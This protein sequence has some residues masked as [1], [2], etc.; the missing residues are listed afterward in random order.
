MI[1]L[2]DHLS[3]HDIFRYN[4]P[5]RNDV[6]T[7]ASDI[8]GCLSRLDRIYVSLNLTRSALCTTRAVNLTDHKLF[9]VKINISFCSRGRGYY[10][11]NTL[12]L[13]D[14][15]VENFVKERLQ[16]LSTPAVSFDAWENFKIDVIGYFRRLGKN[17]AKDRNLNRKSLEDRIRNVQVLLSN[18]QNPELRSYLKKLHE[19]LE[20]TNSFYIA[21]CRHN[22]Y[23][24]DF[25]NDK[26]SIATAKALQRKD[27]EQRH[28]FSVL[29]EDGSVATEPES[30]K[31]A[32]RAFY[33]DIFK[34]RRIDQELLNHFIES[35]QPTLSEEEQDT[36]NAEIFE[37]EVLFA[38]RSTQGKKTPGLDG[39]PI[40]FYWKFC[41]ELVPIL[42]KLYNGF[43][44]AGKMHDSA[45]QG[46]ISLLYKGKG[47]RNNLANW[48]P[49]TMLNLDYK[50]YAK[51]L[52]RRVQTVIASVVRAD[53]SCAVPGRTILDSI[54]SV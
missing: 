25:V 28:I 16:E 24:S 32:A 9:R 11:L 13:S 44:N 26:L 54:F 36:L 40:E 37:E 15:G 38:I 31:S 33:Q 4:N 18:D 29:M 35:G 12:L 22:T 51:V 41:N 3:V 2:K 7:F 46:V 19:E 17:K 27:W 21:S 8:N 45:Y 39:I 48:R 49:L 30:I 53:R 42:T 23:Y 1:E 52:S 43:L 20:L 5:Q 10:K 6:F 34:S 47:D 14:F 50:I